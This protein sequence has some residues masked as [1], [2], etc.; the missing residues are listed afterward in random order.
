MVG[1]DHYHQPTLKSNSLG[2]IADDRFQKLALS[3]AQITRVEEKKFKPHRN[4]WVGMIHSIEKFVNV[5]KAI[6][7]EGCFQEVSTDD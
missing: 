5:F 7:N 3:E 2:E 6:H 4:S 1:L